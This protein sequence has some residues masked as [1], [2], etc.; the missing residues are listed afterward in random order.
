MKTLEERLS[1]EKPWINSCI[2]GTINE[3]YD[4]SLKD[5]FYVNI[6]RDWLMNTKFKPGKSCTS[7]FEELQY[8][9]DC[10]IK[11]LMTDKSIK[12]HDADLIR[13][14]FKVY[15][16]FKSRESNL[17]RLKGH[18][19]IV[20]D[21]ETLDQLSQYFKSEECEKHGCSIIHF[22]RALDL[23]ETNKYCIGISTIGLTFGDSD[24]YSKE[25][26]SNGQKK[27]DYF[28]KILK[29]VM[30]RFGYTDEEYNDIL[31]MRYKFEFMAAHHIDSYEESSKPD[32]IEKIYNPVTL[33]KLNEMSKVF[34]IVD[35]MKSSKISHSKLITLYEPKYLEFLNTIYI[36]D[37]VELI[38]SYLISCMLYSYINYIDEESFRY[39]MKCYYERCGI[40]TE[41]PDDE[42]FSSWVNSTLPTCT[43]KAYLAK[44]VDT[45]IKSEIEELIKKIIK[46]YKKMLQSQKWL[47]DET[48]SKAIDKLDHLTIHV[49]NPDKWNDYSGLSLF[50][51]NNLYDIITTINDYKWKKFTLDR[52]NTEKDREMWAN[53]IT[54]VNA[55]CN[56][57]ENAIIITA[58]IL[59]GS[60]Y[61]KDM[62]IEE[63]LGAIGVIIG[64]EISHCFDTNGAQFDK[65]GNFNNWWNEEDLKNFRDRCSKIDTYFDEMVLSEDGTHYKGILVNKEFTADITGM[66]CMLTI[67]KKIKNFDYDKFFRSYA[68]LWKCLRTQ[69]SMDS[70]IKTDCHEVECLR[71]NCVLQQFDE[72]INTYDLSKSDKMYLDKD[73]RISIW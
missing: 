69:E 52:I 44:Y 23:K 49:V 62:T 72:F 55:Y 9:I 31:E 70:L 59:N 41:M 11:D 35:I 2:M 14:L 21:I 46:V 15:M 29:Y 18:I 63:K 54:S 6:N 48:K 73:K 5:D 37:N 43:S 12:T 32:Y 1:I 38:K 57:L 24:E 17:D 26:T 13:K 25:L 36:Q 16:D 71:V 28:E 42:I 3:S 4:P 61:S 22:G 40:T 39:F 67:A 53:D 47:S 27:K 66:K 68:R 8:I 10:N 65:D 20:Q 19:K 45:S 50:K 64:H 30:Q 60:F 58:G 56:Q 51:L 34:P 7:S 33:D